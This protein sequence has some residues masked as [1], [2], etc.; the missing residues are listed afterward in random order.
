[1][2]TLT[3]RICGKL[4]AMEP[5][6]LLRANGFGIAHLKELNENSFTIDEC[7]N[8]GMYNIPIIGW[9]G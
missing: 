3:R 4:S 2:E 1:M 6:L 7:L 5:K 9:F 8:Y